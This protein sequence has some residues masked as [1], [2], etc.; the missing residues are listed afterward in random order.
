MNCAECI[1]LILRCTGP[2]ICNSPEVKALLGFSYQNSS[3]VCTWSGNMHFF[4]LH[5]LFTVKS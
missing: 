2:V 3:G 4:D 5:D 1:F